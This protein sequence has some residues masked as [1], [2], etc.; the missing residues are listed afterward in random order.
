MKNS[1]QTVLVF[2][3]VTVKEAMGLL[4][5]SGMQILLVVDRRRRLLGTLTDG[6]IRRHVLA[7]GSLKLTVS[8]I[9]N[10]S[11]K[12]IKEGYSA[13]QV[14]NLMR[15]KHVHHVPVVDE[16]GRVVDLLRW[17]DFMKSG[18]G[19]PAAK[20]LGVPVV[21]MAG[22]KGVRLDPFTRILPKPLIPVE[23]KPLVQVIMDQFVEQGCSRFFMTVNYKAEMIRSYF[24]GGDTNGKYDIRYVHEREATGTAG[25]LVSLAT[26]IRGDFFISN[27]D[28]VI[29]ADYRD[30][31]RY[32]RERKYTLTMVASMQSFRVPYGVI[33]LGRGGGLKRILEKPEYDLLANTGL[34][35]LSDGVRRFFPRKAAFDMPELIASVRAKGGSV[36][37]YPVSR[38][39]WTDVGQWSEYFRHL[40]SVRSNQ[41]A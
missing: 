27:C 19:T 34:Y 26:K 17:E 36:G 7:E 23:D 37:V 28:V 8:S 33:E 21:I 14:Q 30:L 35:V 4:D 25:S 39:A 29:K 16:S 12:S 40:L 15:E 22:G 6:D 18:G 24:D 38:G 2:P 1:L 41:D 13:V 20:P 5:K 3:S 32:H 31:L 9:C 11:P 10:R